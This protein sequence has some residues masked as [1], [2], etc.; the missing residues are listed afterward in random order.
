MHLRGSGSVTSSNYASNFVKDE[1][2][3][4]EHVDP[5]P[6][7]CL[8]FGDALPNESPRNQPSVYA[9]ILNWNG[10]QDT[11]HCLHSL[12]RMGYRNWR[13]VIVD[14]GSTDDSVERF[15]VACPETPILETHRNLGFAAGNNIGIRFALNNDADYVF[16][17]NNDTSLSPDAISE[18][19]AFSERHPEAA[20]IGPRIARRN[21]QL[22]WPICRQL[23]LLTIICAYTPLRR[24]IARIPVVRAMFYYLENQPSVVRFVPGSALFFRA[25]AFEK[26][27]LFDEST[28]LD[29]EELIMAEKVRSAGYSVCFVP[30]A[31]I[32][33]KG[34]A[35]ASGLRAKRYIENAKSEEY[36]FSHYVHLSRIGKSILKLVRFVS[37]GARAVRYRNYREHFNEF[38]DALLARQR[39]RVD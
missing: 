21:P 23:D 18:C 20:L 38:M 29:Y 10:W 32:W 2:G 34:S 36:F 19:V 37:Y 22:E 1:I 14:N 12:R 4:V 17:L 27:G 7:H 31:T 5:R 39:F 25:A 9:V 33:H 8:Q 3:M 28:F 16:I 26:T 24:L 30:S 11:L 6:G 13:A 35:S 15:K